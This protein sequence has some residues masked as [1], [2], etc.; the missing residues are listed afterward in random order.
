MEKPKNFMDWLKQGFGRGIVDIFLAPYNRKVG[1]CSHL[2]S[3]GMQ[4]V[5]LLFRLMMMMVVVVVV[6]M[7]PGVGL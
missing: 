3:L 7:T 1:G 4:L 5:F 2:G 6:V